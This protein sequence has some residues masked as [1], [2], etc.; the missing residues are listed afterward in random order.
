MPGFL[1]FEEYKKLG[2]GPDTPDILK[3]GLRRL[4]MAWIAHGI[5]GEYNIDIDPVAVLKGDGTDLLNL[6]EAYAAWISVTSINQTVEGAAQREREDI[7]QQKGK[8]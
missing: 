7:E 4:P 8:A 3:A 1:M 2:I 5:K 6:G